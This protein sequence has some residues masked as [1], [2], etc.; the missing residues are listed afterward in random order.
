MQ[1]LI[2]HPLITQGSRELSILDGVDTGAGTYTSVRTVTA[3]ASILPAIRFLSMLH[4]AC[5]S[6]N[7]II[8]LGFNFRLPSKLT[9]KKFTHSLYELLPVIY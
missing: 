9:H 1:N 5:S 4:Q 3:A 2:K 8:L 7:E 6:A